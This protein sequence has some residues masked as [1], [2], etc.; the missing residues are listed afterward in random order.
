MKYSTEENYGIAEDSIANGAPVAYIVN[1]NPV[2]RM[3]YSH[4]HTY[5]EFTFMLNG[6]LHMIIENDTYAT[7]TGQFVIFAP[8]I[9]HNRF[10]RQTKPGERFVMYFTE[11]LLVEAFEGQIAKISGN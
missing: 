5:Y 6:E 3:A 2:D 4:Y 8:F 1:N 9:L 11:E 7:Y 10:S